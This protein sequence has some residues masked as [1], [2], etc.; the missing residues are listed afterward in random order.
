LSG[1]SNQKFIKEKIIMSVEVTY[2]IW[3]FIFCV[4][5]L[6]IGVYA[7]KKVKNSEDFMVAGRGLPF[8]QP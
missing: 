5:M 1:D 6:G 4:A 2:G 8:W 7:S 3:M